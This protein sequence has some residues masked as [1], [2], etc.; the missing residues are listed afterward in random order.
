MTDIRTWSPCLLTEC[1]PTHQ[2]RVFEIKSM[3]FVRKRFVRKW[4]SKSKEMLRKSWDSNSK[5]HLFYV[6]EI[7]ISSFFASSFTKIET[8]LWQ[9]LLT[10]IQLFMTNMVTSFIQF[11]PTKVKKTLWKPQPQFREKLK[12]TW[13]SQKVVGALIKKSVLGVWLC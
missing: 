13:G 1:F 8:L 10:K 11:T 7:D 9:S 4:G 2:D 6:P 5:I 12:K 3:S